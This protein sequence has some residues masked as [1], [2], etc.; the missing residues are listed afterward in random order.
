[1]CRT[2][3]SN[4]GN[5]KRT[6]PD[7]SDVSSRLFFRMFFRIIPMHITIIIGPGLLGGHPLATLI[8][9]IRINMFMDMI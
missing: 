8:L 6:S 1:M 2:R 7:I 3:V 4:S 9:F 5:G